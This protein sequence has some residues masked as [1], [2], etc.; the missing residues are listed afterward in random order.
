MPKRII[1]ILLGFALLASLT[2]GTTAF[3]KKKETENK[4]KTE[5]AK[6]SKDKPF[7]EVIKDFKK[8][9]GFFTFYVDEEEGKTYMAVE[10]SFFDKLFICSLART[11]ADGS[12]FDSGADIGE[13]V[14]EFKRVGKTIQ[15]LESN[16]RFRADSTSALLP[17]VE[18]GVSKSI[19]G[20]AKIESAPD[21]NNA[22]L[23][24]P[25]GFFIKDIL[26]ISYY[27]GTRAKLG[28]SFD[29]KNS[30]FGTIKS[31]PENSEF[32][33][34]LHYKTAKPNSATTLPSPYSMLHTY[35]YSIMAVPETDYVPRL[36]DDRVGYFQAIYQ[37]YTNLDSETPYI[38]YITRWNLKKKYPD[39][40]ISPPIDPIEF[41]IGK[42]V[43]EE[44]REYVKQGVLYWDKAFRAAGFE[45]AIVVKQMPDTA[46]WDPAD[47]RYNVI[48]WIVFPGQSYAVGP[49]HS[50]PFTGEIYDADIRV[51]VDFIRYMYTYSE[52]FI[53]PVRPESDMMNE[54]LFIGPNRYGFPDNYAMGKSKDAAFAMSLLQVRNDLDNKSDLVK[55][56]VR[57]YIIDLVAHEVGHT[58]GLKHNFK[59]SIYLTPSEM[60]DTSLTRSI[61][62]VASTMDYNPANIALPDE[63][64]GD[65]YNLTPGP[66][67][68]LAIEYGYREYGTTLP[69]EEL[70]RLEAIASRSAEF[71]HEYGS[72]EDALGNGV[73]A[74]DPECHQFDLGKDPLEYYRR[75]IV[76]SKELWK[77]MEEKFS[78]YDTRFSKLR[79]VFGRGFSAYAG[80]ASL[81]SRYVSGIY[82]HR[83]HI[84]TPGARK[85]M[86]PVPAARQREALEFLKTNIFAADAFEFPARIINKL[87]SNRMPDF[88]GSL[89]RITRIDYPLHNVV[90]AIQANVMN[91]LYHPITLQRLHDLP[92]H[93]PP[94][95]DAF[96][97]TEMFTSLRRAIWSP[98]VIRGDNVNSFRRN[99]QRLHLDRIINIATGEGPMIPEDARTLA[100][101]DL[102]VLKGAIGKALN[103]PR[104][105]TISRG[106]YE[107]SLAR[108]EAAM[109][110]SLVRKVKL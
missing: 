48:Q 10:P 76:L 93:Y 62:M 54:G 34:H 29:E 96:T 63:D 23:V 84:G 98:E 30:Y 75:R 101:V 60:N 1:T 8:I 14:F 3:A 69:Q 89:Y 4:K 12:Y 13:F 90:L 47:T 24:D 5:E 26:N 79:R 100:R 53:E 58:L 72:D 97:M 109:E 44:Y 88:S 65:F 15:L 94:G 107:E 92:L 17:A 67:D 105:N 38:Y 77:N 104:L 81:A 52:E 70:P 51:C 82:T 85:P 40:E 16:V 7:D 95:E 106:H 41:W 43:P 80:G 83:D 57:Q 32:D 22:V 27:L 35:H 59:A 6:K 55:K 78:G 25:S 108:I 2:P 46:T 33:V 39:R 71:G 56:Y 50:N 18:K 74:I 64:Q 49:S 28:Y 91:R 110:A 102:K 36:A 42:T 68:I 31:F 87:Q 66:Y 103:S 99:L 37:D 9:E 21:S 73:R 20:A 61:G 86:S 45:D 19:Y 11:A